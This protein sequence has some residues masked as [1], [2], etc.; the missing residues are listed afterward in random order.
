[1]RKLSGYELVELLEKEIKK[2]FGK[3]CKD[4]QYSCIVCSV[5]LALNI[6][7]DSYELLPLTGATKTIKG[8][9]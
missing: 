9:I 7:K 6:L 1:M 8:E 4:F 2:D 5:Y 3:K